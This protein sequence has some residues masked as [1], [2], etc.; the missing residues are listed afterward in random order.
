M[1]NYKQAQSFSA[2]NQKT[3]VI[4]PHV[5]LV[6]FG[7]SAKNHLNGMVVADG[8]YR[9]K[10]FFTHIADRGQRSRF[11]KQGLNIDVVEL[12]AGVKVY[13]NWYIPIEPE[14]DRIRATRL[15][16][17]DVIFIFG[18]G[19]KLKNLV[20]K[21]KEMAI[22][23]RGQRWQVYQVLYHD[24]KYIKFIPAQVDKLPE[25][26]LMI[27]PKE[28]EKEIVLSLFEQVSQ[29]IY[30][31]VVSSLNNIQENVHGK[32]HL[33][34][35]DGTRCQA[36]E[37]ELDMLRCRLKEIFANS[38]LLDDLLTKVDEY[39]TK[40]LDVKYED[41][42]VFALDPAF[43]E[44]ATRFLRQKVSRI[45][46]IN[47]GLEVPSTEGRQSMHNRPDKPYLDMVK[48]YFRYVGD[49]FDQLDPVCKVMANEIK[50]AADIYYA[51]QAIR[52][53]QHSIKA[54][55]KNG[56]HDDG[57]DLL[58]TI[59]EL[60]TDLVNKIIVTSPN[61]AAKLIKDVDPRTKHMSLKSYQKQ[62]DSPVTPRL[63]HAGSPRL[64]K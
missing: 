3:H 40:T 33:L 24:N 60:I 18:R 27:V 4:L 12:E 15:S 41:L 46:R 55:L 17:T 57:N 5:A 48:S 21:Y 20:E 52:T 61:L 29:L 56:F 19:S 38:M 42:T 36:E 11:R 47:G 7:K 8:R 13:K 43:R 16:D 10:H 9:E 53:I 1:F 50:R 51:I 59:Q 26:N 49:N 22:S 45:L 64:S 39:Y 2:I 32:F 35:I 44:N 14:Y 23:L 34:Q 54:F 63:P 37:K 28:K 30:V 62:S 6:Y 31:S 58:M 25:G